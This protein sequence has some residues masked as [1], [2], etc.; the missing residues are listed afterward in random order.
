MYTILGCVAEIGVGPTKSAAI[1]RSYGGVGP[2]ILLEIDP[3]SEELRIKILAASSQQVLELGPKIRRVFHCDHPFEPVQ[4]A[5]RFFHVLRLIITQAFEKS[6]NANTEK[7][8]ERI[9]KLLES[10]DVFRGVMSSIP[11]L[12]AEWSFPFPKSKIKG[13]TGKFGNYK[14]AEIVSAM[15]KLPG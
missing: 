4:D 1:V 10:E 11:V 15:Q 13:W 8:L 9:G 2:S 6:A 12:W 5:V 14:I 7:N 3:S